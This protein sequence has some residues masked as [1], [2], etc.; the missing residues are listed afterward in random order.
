[1]YTIFYCIYK[2][3]HLHVVHQFVLQVLPTSDLSPS[4]NADHKLIPSPKP[5]PSTPEQ[6]ATRSSCS[7][8]VQRVSRRSDGKVSC[9]STSKQEASYSLS[10]PPFGQR[11]P[12][13]SNKRRKL[14][15][16]VSSQGDPCTL[17]NVSDTEIVRL[18][19]SVIKGYHQFRIR[20]PITNPTTYLFVDREY[21][22]IQDV[23]ACLVWI[24]PLTMFDPSFHQLVTDPKRQL[25][26]ADVADLPIGH[27]PRGLAGCFRE[28][29]DLGA[30]IF[31]EVTGDPIPSFPPW[32]ALQAKGGGIVI[33]CT[34]WI[35]SQ[36]KNKILSL[37]SKTL[38][39]MP[40]GASMKIV[41]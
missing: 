17:S 4:P 40:E 7:S 6:S 20:P 2:D 30:S 31:A 26:L 36:D 19:N 5:L 33:P 32:P 14:R 9:I 34:Y 35:Q 16:Y 21:T 38:N 1:M 29:L 37:L 3:M 27:V 23:N 11:S 15:L 13:S 18:Q 39:I 28:I 22:N 10:C 25:T 8:S 24:P 41:Q 12:H